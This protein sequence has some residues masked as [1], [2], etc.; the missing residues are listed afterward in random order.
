MLTHHFCAP[1]SLTL[2]SLR[3]TMK[4]RLNVF[5][6]C[7]SSPYFRISDRS[8]FLIIVN[9]HKKPSDQSMNTSVK[10]SN[11]CRLTFQTSGHHCSSS[12][13]CH[14][15]RMNSYAARYSLLTQQ[16]KNQINSS[17]YF[18]STVFLAWMIS[19]SMKRKVTL[20]SY[21]V[22]VRLPNLKIN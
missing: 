17:Q 19:S 2:F 9:I 11:R 8:F 14:L 12:N 20:L 6:N 15:L 22:Q 21:L 13:T 5:I 4:L 7:R 3:E 10:T 16:F 18:F 1:T